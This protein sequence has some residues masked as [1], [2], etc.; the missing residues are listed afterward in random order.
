M[1]LR[2]AGKKSTRCLHFV[3]SS[4]DHSMQVSDASTPRL[5]LHPV[6]RSLCGLVLSHVESCFFQSDGH[7]F[8]WDELVSAAVEVVAVFPA[9]PEKDVAEIPGP[10]SG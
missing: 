9:K 4:I 10:A 3:Q 7:A 6:R 2:V 1:T 8:T 5:V